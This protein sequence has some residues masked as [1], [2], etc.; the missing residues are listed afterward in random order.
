MP[1][2]TGAGLP[3]AG[4]DIGSYPLIGLMS[5]GL[6]ASLT[7]FGVRSY[8]LRASKTGRTLNP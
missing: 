6:L 5:L 8:G 4:H 7:Q 2:C 1:S 3:L